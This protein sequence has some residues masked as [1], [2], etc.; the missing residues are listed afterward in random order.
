MV[1][2]NHPLQPLWAIPYEALDLF[3]Q[4][5]QL[6]K[7]I[8]WSTSGAA[9]AGGVYIHHRFQIPVTGVEAIEET[10]EQAVQNRLL[11]WKTI[12]T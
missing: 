8:N 2:S 12:H 9:G 6:D 5:Y 4:E 11:I 10:Y 3:F 1:I 7:R